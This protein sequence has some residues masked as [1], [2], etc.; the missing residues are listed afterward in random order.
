VD[1]RGD[2][3]N[4]IAIAA[5]LR[6]AGL[7]SDSLRVTPGA[8][9]ARAS[10]LVRQRDG[11]RQIVFGPSSAAPPE[12]GEQE[13]A[14]LRQARL[15]HL[16]G[17]H[18]ETA[19]QAVASA[20]KLNVEISFDGGAGRYRHSIR[21]FV[22]ASHVRIVAWD[23]ARHFSGSEAVSDMM[24]ALLEPP[25]R[26]AVITAGTLGSH[27]ATPGHAIRHQPAHQA[28]P[29]VDTTGC[30]D[31]YHGAFLHGWLLGW[32][33]S[34]CADFASRLAAINAEGLGGRFCL[35]KPLVCE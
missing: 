26:L 17:R 28:S 12:W 21:N 9:S 34:R 2:D 7:R 3:A 1:S 15:L 27:I 29:V 19:T 30:G 35:S 6:S 10:V 18:E 31:V 32:E 16:N 22:S 4:G 11:A 20:Q 14:L 25:A 33:P 8:T 5:D 13:V 24:H 23:F